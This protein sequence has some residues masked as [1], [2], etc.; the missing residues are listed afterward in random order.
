[1]DRPIVSSRDSSHQ[2]RDYGLNSRESK[3][4]RMVELHGGEPI[5]YEKPE[6]CVTGS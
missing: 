5:I 3:V 6:K 2:E 4:L 1:M